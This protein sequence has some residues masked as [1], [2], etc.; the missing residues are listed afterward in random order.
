MQIR[1]IK[2]IYYLTQNGDKVTL[3]YVSVDRKRNDEFKY[4]L[5]ISK[6]GDYYKFTTNIGSM[7]VKMHTKGTSFWFK[8]METTYTLTNISNMLEFRYHSLVENVTMSGRCICQYHNNYNFSIF[9]TREEAEKSLKRKYKKQITCGI[10][11]LKEALRRNSYFYKLEM[12]K[13][14]DLDKKKR[15]R[16]LHNTKKYIFKLTELHKSIK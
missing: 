6:G 3:Y 4:F 15:L 12:E 8:E 11:D 14:C 9:T 2:D 5:D 7:D 10:N 13:L 1:S 16:V